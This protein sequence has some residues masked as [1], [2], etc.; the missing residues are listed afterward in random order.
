MAND[1]LLVDDEANVLHGLSRAL[2]DQP[3]RVY[4][5]RSAEEALPI[6]KSHPIAVAVCDEQMSGRKGTELFAWMA[7]HCPEVTRIVL[8]GHSSPEMTMRA[9]ND[10]RVFRYFTKPCHPVEIAMAIRD[11]IDLHESLTGA[12]GGA[13]IAV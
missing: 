10:G 9:I 5:A 2:R 1:V 7:Q 4:T 11:G 12:G 3:Y 13:T 6:I 8:S